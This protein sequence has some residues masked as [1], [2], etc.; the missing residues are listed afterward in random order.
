MKLYTV[1]ETPTTGYIGEMSFEDILLKLKTNEIKEDYVT[2]EFSAPYAELIKRKGV[3]WIK[4]SNLVSLLR[5]RESPTPKT[6]DEQ[7]FSR[8]GSRYRD[9]YLVASAVAAIGVAVKV[10]GII[11]GLLTMCAGLLAGI[12]DNGSPQFIIGGLLLGA[13]VAIPIFVLGVLVSA[14]AQVLKATLD[15][16]VHSSPFLKKED[17]ARVMSL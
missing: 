4:V 12:H 3:Y 1:A 15:T 8:V 10:I 9:A 2:T 17:M 6:A 16:A 11:L 7:I 5:Q 14:Q 13:I